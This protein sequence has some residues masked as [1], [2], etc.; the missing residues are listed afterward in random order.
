MESTPRLSMSSF[1]TALFALFPRPL[2]GALRLIKFDE[3][4]SAPY[5]AELDISSLDINISTFC[6][7]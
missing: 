3:K 1:V 7:H 6:R 2:S 4:A 5:M